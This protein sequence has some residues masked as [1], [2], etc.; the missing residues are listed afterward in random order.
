MSFDLDYKLFSDYMTT[1][2]LDHPEFEKMMQYVMA[3][4]SQTIDFT[5]N[6]FLAWR[7]GKIDW[8]MQNRLLEFEEKGSVSS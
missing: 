8:F 1:Y 2:I 6:M 5:T 7:S 3:H 4:K